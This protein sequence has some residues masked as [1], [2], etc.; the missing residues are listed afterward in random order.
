MPLT[1]RISLV[2]GTLL[3]LALVLRRISKRK[4]RV[5]DAVYWVVSMLVLVLLALFPGVAILISGWLG[6]L[7]PSNFVFVTIIALMLLTLFGLA[8]DVSRLTDKVERLS[9]EIALMNGDAGE[10]QGRQGERS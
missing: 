10:G 2:V 3:A 8:S 4:I 7:S 5:A 6:F 1:L 9:Q